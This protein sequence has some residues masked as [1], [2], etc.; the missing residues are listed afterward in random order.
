MNKS[1]KN[2][3]YNTAKSNYNE[4]KPKKYTNKLDSLFEKSLSASST[5]K[6]EESYE[7][8]SSKQNHNEKKYENENDYYQHYSEN[9]ENAYQEEYSNY[10][11][12]YNFGRNKHK[13]Y[14]YNN[15]YNN[16]YQKKYYQKQNY[17]Q[18]NNAKENY[19]N[20]PSRADKDDEYY[21]NE[22]N[23]NDAYYYENINIDN[24]EYS[25]SAKPN[26]N[27][28]SNPH[29]PRN[30]R[31][32]KKKQNKVYSQDEK[33]KQQKYQ[34][35]KIVS[36]LTY[37]APELTYNLINELIEAEYE[38]MICNDV[39]NQTE[40]TWGC[41]KCYTI[42]HI[43]CIYDWIFKLNAEKPDDS[44]YKNKK[45]A[46]IFKWSCP[47]CNFNYTATTDNL[48][49]YNCFCK[50]Y[51][52][53]QEGAQK[54]IEEYKAFNP[55][56][57]P[58]GCGLLCNSKVCRH[59]TCNLP[60]HPGPHLACNEIENLIC[61]C[62]NSKK[63]VACASLGPNSDRN[64]AC[65][66][67][68]GKLLNCKRH[69]CK[70]FC[71]EAECE[72]LFRLKKCEECTVEAKLKF[73]NF[74][75]GL[76]AKIKIDFKK[77]VRFAED[78][79]DYIFHGMLLC[80]SHFVETNTD[81]NLR[82][83][84]KLVQISGNALIENIKKFIPLCKETVDNSCNCKSKSTKT[85]CFKLN[86]KE[87]VIDFLGLADQ[88]EKP[89][90]QCAKVCKA[91][92]SCKNHTCDRICCELANV[93]ISNYSLD[94]PNGLHL[95]LTICNKD[96][97]CG[98]HKCENY[99][100]RGNCLSCKTIIREGESVCNCGNTRIKAPF[101]CG[102][103]PQCKLPCI[104]E[105]NCP[106]P[107]SLSCHDG[108]CPSC[109]EKV[110]K[111]CNCGKVA[112]ENVRCG[113][114]ELPKCNSVCDEMLPCGAH[115]CD[116]VCHNH[117]E[118]YDKNYFCN[119]ACGRQFTFCKHNCKKRCHGE[120]DCWEIE[121][122]AKVKISCKCKVNK[123]DF[124]CG[125]VK[126]LSNNCKED[127]FISCNDECKKIERLKKIEVAFDGLFKYNQ[128]KN[129][130]LLKG[131][132]DVKNKENPKAAAAAKKSSGDNAKVITR[133]WGNKDSSNINNS[134]QAGEKY[135]KDNELYANAAEKFETTQIEIE[136]EEKKKKKL[137]I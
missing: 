124:K 51:Y 9:T 82:L 118:E 135:E 131:I 61:F 37:K 44:L 116:L 86:Y 24:K 80:K 3:G 28:T 25:Q 111:V 36:K 21:Y 48:P 11:S 95:C 8:N 69:K 45:V 133:N 27:K 67:I 78:L 49:K 7:Q 31:V 55:G 34:I 42:Y 102:S 136:N 73:M 79:A 17:P 81:D 77:E 46:S 109:E 115:F 32:N 104:R 84:I 90:D 88:K 65:E 123:K 106:H 76:E 71:H 5:K 59:V 110:I 43:S 58:H 52:K 92:K 96:L 22:S 114:A 134:N 94:D 4:S 60:C 1:Y 12:A 33:I 127:Y 66:R 10:N 97:N 57:I 113:E 20:T 14:N 23:K 125:E 108:L 129:R 13:N 29:N 103:K 47:H 2:S 132:G 120:S 62:G 91:L 74:L 63:E 18:E 100:H 53:A 19:E 72:A 99:C 83:L 75:N 64:F 117:S 98:E 137:A 121:C 85:E 107:C 105:R 16:D 30:K 130:Q 68:C 50:R 39:V 122:D 70:S 101:T 56:L 126:K 15:N 128:E 87:D 35:E 38:C 6:Q 54:G 119:L 41:N 26:G 93:K 112:I 89:L 40:E